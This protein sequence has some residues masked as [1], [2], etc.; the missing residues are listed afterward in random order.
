MEVEIAF[1]LISLFHVQIQEPT[2]R[3]TTMTALVFLTKFPEFYYHKI[4]ERS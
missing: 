3:S 1:E 2:S 4:F